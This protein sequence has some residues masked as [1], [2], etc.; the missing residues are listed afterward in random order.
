M[1]LTQKEQDSFWADA[2]EFD[3][4]IPSY[5]FHDE[6]F[7]LACDTSYVVTDAVT[8]ADAVE[9]FSGLSTG[10]VAIYLYRGREHLATYNGGQGEPECETVYQVTKSAL[11][12]WLAVLSSAV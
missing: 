8:L 7:Y 2:T 3:G 11:P 10:M 12:E 5:R 4:L 9:L 6:W 1:T